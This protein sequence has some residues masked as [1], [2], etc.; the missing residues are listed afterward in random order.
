MSLLNALIAWYFKSRLQTVQDAMD[1]AVAIQKRTLVELLER[2]AQ[3]TF[4]KEHHFAKIRDYSDFVANVPVMDYEDIKPYVERM[5]KGE[6]NVLWPGVI[7]WFAKSSGTTNDKSKFIPVSSETLET[8]HFEGGR[9]ALTIYFKDH[10]DSKLFEGKGLLIGGSHNVSNLNAHTHFGDLSALLMKH[11]P[12]WVHLF[13]TPNASVA[14][15]DDWEQKLEKMVDQT[16]KENVTNISG[17]PTW[18]TV[19]FDRLLEKTGK[20]NMLEV[21]PN[22]ELY[23]HGG[24]SFTPYRKQFE[25][26]LPGKQ[27]TYLETYNAS[28]GFFGLQTQPQSTALSLMVH[29]GIFYEFI[30]LIGMGMEGDKPLPLWEVVT[31]QHYAI[32]ISNNSGLWRYR[33]GDTICFDSIKPYTFHI[34]GR[35]RLFINAFGEELMIDNTDK[36]MEKACLLHQATLKD[37]TAAPIYLEDPANAGHEWLIEFEV[38]PA[39][40]EAFTHD[41]DSALKALNSDYEAKRHKDIA[42]KKPTVKIVP[43]NT[44]HKWLQS[45]D[46][47]GGQHKVPR[48]WNDRTIVN[49][50]HSLLQNQPLNE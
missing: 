42:L 13:K 27:V 47:L 38:P 10:P 2:A 20:S 17:V 40:L 48:L 22:L 23:I 32:L 49:E 29:Y 18:T 24:V 37:Y 36:A 16:H 21:W 43:K 34:T 25:R 44:F 45:K 41:L 7:S 33:L 35:T 14:L 5:M 9:D 8:C 19:L 12:M 30:P 1:N 31:G 6:A 46:K 39:D 15:M 26:Y 4:G 50:V 3:T 11:M 28:E